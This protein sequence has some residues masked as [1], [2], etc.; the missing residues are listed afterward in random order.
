MGSGLI[1]Q[2]GCV[3]MKG[4]IYPYNPV[5]YEDRG[6]SPKVTRITD[7]TWI[8][9]HLYFTNCSFTP[10]DKKIIF[11]SE[12]DGGN[13]LFCL[14]LEKNEIKQLTERRI[15]DYFPHPSRDGK[16]VFF[17][18][19]RYVMSVDI[20]TCEEEILLDANELV[21]HDVY[22]CSGTNPSWDGTKLINFFEAA[23]D[24]GFIVTDLITGQSEIILRG[25]QPVRHSQFCPTDSNLILYAHE[26]KSWDKTRMWLIDADGSNN[27]RVRIDPD[28]DAVHC[29]HESWSHHEKVVYF[30]MRI[31]AENK[32]Y[33][34]RRNIETNEETIMFPLD[35]FHMSISPDDTMIAGDNKEGD[36]Q[37]HIINMA[38]AEVKSLCYPNMSFRGGPIASRFHP[39]PTFNNKGDKVIYSTDGF[40]YPGV[41]VAE[42]P[43]F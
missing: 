1:K 35:Q 22:K 7:E 15:L 38:N 26:G 4:K 41:F 32:T 23:P 36:R 17:G 3:N 31:R 24:Y 29:F 13:N 30:T 8:A 19:G 10:D 21:G 2:K 6:V 37:I 12:I 5:V 40:A 27:R 11:E 25:D 28:G 34:T 18:E 20:E 16:K 42:V 43:K 9:N 33:F 14:D 39:H